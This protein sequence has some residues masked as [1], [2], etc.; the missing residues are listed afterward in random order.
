MSLALN[1]S[2]VPSYKIV[3]RDESS[4]SQILKPLFSCN[5]LGNLARVLGKV[6]VDACLCFGKH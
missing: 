1:A 3:V 6:L 2:E 4:H 5:S